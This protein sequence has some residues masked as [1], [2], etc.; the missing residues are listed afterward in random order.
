[1]QEDSCPLDDEVCIIFSYI[2]LCQLAAEDRT[3]CEIMYSSYLINTF[4]N[5]GF[6]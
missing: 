2:I 5:N 1:M 6:V 4:V 3:W